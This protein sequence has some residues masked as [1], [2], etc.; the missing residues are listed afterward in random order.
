MTRGAGVRAVAVVAAAAACATGVL[1]AFGHDPLVAARVLV[2][3]TVGSP[4]NAAVTLVKSAPLLLLGVAVALS[5][6][7][8]VWNVGAEGQFTAGAIAATAVGVNAA[9]LGSALALPLLLACGAAGG[10]VAALPPA[11][12]KRFRGTNEVIGTIMMNFLIAFALSFALDGPLRE[13]AGTFPQSDYLAEPARLPRFDEASRLHA[14]LP[15][16]VVVAIAAHVF[17]TR[18]L[19]GLRWRALGDNPAAA[20][21]LGLP[22]SRLALLALVASG[23]IAGLAGAIEVA[24]ITRRLF[25]GFS[26]GVGYAAIAVALLGGRSIPGVVAAA[27]LLGALDV[28]SASLE[29]AAG[30][31]SKLALVVQALLLGAAALLAEHRR[32][33]RRGVVPEA[34]A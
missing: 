26:G 10:A 14:G 27:L 16:A 7:A 11:L 33:A 22:A 19:A 4:Q 32:R 9:G 6:R 18:T 8:G 3:S 28:G 24:A 2:A 31:P 17:L 23:A 30:V 21:A 34:V 1:V 12:L 20:E 13:A 29:R 5:F 15:V 25:D